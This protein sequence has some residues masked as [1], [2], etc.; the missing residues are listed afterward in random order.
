MTSIGILDC[1]VR[2]LP[3]RMLRK[4]GIDLEQ[5]LFVAVGQLCIEG[6]GWDGIV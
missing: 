5:I 6:V 2:R 3:Q 4:E 1:R